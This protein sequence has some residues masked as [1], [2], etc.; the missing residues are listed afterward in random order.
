M[1]LC[2]AQVFGCES[3]S[4]TKQTQFQKFSEKKTSR[5]LASDYASNMCIALCIYVT[6]GSD[7]VLG[8][9]YRQF[10]FR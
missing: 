2:N 9:M 6:D 10:L 3:L 1:L 7:F 8:F 4:P 5:I